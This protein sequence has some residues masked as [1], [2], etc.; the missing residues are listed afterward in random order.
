MIPKQIE[1]DGIVKQI[2]EAMETKEHLRSTLLVLCGDHGMND[3]GNHGGSADSETSPALVF[4]SPKLQTISGGSECPVTQPVGDFHY[5]STVEQSD[6]A[7][8]MAGLLGFPIPLNNLGV[9][10]PEF[11]AFWR[12]GLF[13]HDE[14]LHCSELRLTLV[15]EERISLMQQNAYQIMRVVKETFVGQSFERQA[16]VSDCSHEQSDGE[17]ISCLWSQA[18]HILDSRDQTNADEV[19]RAL[20]AVSLA[21]GN[22]GFIG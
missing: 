6:I 9:F 12:K 11:L 8:T 1:M 15:Q 16:V 5:Y 2:Y 3:A 19:L 17:L 20:T 22:L 14:S 10:I 21:P 4:I 13:N 7:P 18:I